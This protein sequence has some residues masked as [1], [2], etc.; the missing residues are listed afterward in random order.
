V[1]SSTH[2]SARSRRDIQAAVQ[3][4]EHPDVSLPQRAN[5]V[6]LGRKP[7]QPKQP[8]LKPA[9]DHDAR[10]QRDDGSG[11]RARYVVQARADRYHTV[12]LPRRFSPTRRTRHIDTTFVYYDSVQAH[13]KQAAR[14]VSAAFGPHTRIAPLPAE[15]APLA[16]ESGNP[17]RRDRR[18]LELHR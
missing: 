14:E 3:S 2:S 10:P 8:L 13:A 15:I 6:A 4:F 1:A 11:P 7:Q 16:Q 17:A 12:Q 5:A 9:Q 18:R